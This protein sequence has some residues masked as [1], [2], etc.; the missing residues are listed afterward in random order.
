MAIRGLVA[1]GDILRGGD[2]LLV[3]GVLHTITHP[4]EEQLLLQFEWIPF[5][6]CFI[7]F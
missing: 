4:S 1:R 3:L 7:F 5:P 6:Y 2:S